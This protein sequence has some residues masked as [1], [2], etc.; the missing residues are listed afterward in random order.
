MSR[1]NLELVRT[2]I[3][4]YNRGDIEAMRATM[5]RD[6][7]FRT[8]G[9]FPDVDPVYEGHA[10]FRR[11]Y[12][13]FNGTWE[14]FSVSIRELRDCGEQGLMLGVFEGRARDGLQVRRQTASV[15]TFRDALVLAIQNYGGWTQALEA[16]GLR[17]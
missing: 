11:F 6:F 7:E 1:E 4:A 10:G 2:W 8:S 16:V 9:T 12:E 14:A 5:H 3:D 15:W 17:E 13:D